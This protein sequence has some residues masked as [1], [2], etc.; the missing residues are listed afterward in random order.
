LSRKLARN[1]GRFI[2]LGMGAFSR[3]GGNRKAFLKSHPSGSVLAG[4]QPLRPP[5]SLEA[6]PT[7]TGGPRNR[8]ATSIRTDDGAYR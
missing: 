4:R 1:P 3:E 5:L 6:P 7:I 8:R 2:A